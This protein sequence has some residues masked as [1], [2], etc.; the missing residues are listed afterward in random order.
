V[1]TRLL[2]IAALVSTALAQTPAFEVASVKQ[3][4]VTYGM[5]RRPWSPNIQCAPI[6][7]CG[8]AG[9][10]F[11][12]EVASLT[13]LIMD[14]Y[15]VRR[16]QITGLPSWGDSGHDVYD[17]NAT[18]AGDHPP[19][20]NEAHRMLQT[21]LADRFQ[22]KLHH[23]TREL[24]V[25]ELVIGKNGSKLVPVAEGASL[26]CPATPGRVGGGG[27]LDE[28][29]AF[30]RSWIGVPEI[31]SNLAGR[32]VIDKTGYEIRAYC[33]LDGQDPMIAIM[34]AFSGGGGRGG[35]PSAA[36]YDAPSV[37][38]E[39]DEKW[40]MKLVPEKGPVDILVIDHV[41]RPAEN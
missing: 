38:T 27:Q 28:A 20:L 19:S 37:F 39:I 12:D 32:P 26:V 8:I 41:E 1:T 18:V 23:E 34:A 29:F 2:L 25:Y 13:D 17:V 30:F 33:T 4:A 5:I 40:G 10:K 16:Y 3:H 15:S 11:N 14:A 31:L 6:A 9:N 21:L 22:L 7:R 24:P 35:T 36:A